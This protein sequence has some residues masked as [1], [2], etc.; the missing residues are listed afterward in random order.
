MATDIIYPPTTMSFNT[1]K[2]YSIDD[3]YFIKNQIRE[4]LGNINYFS[5]E[6]RELFEKMNQ[7]VPQG[8]RKKKFSPDEDWRKK[9][10]VQF[11]KKESQDQNEKIYHELKGYLNKISLNNYQ[12][13]LEEI[14]KLLAT[15]QDN[16]EY[17]LNILLNDILKKARAEPTYCVYYV[18]IILGLTDKVNV[19]KFINE[20]KGNYYQ[21]INKLRPVVE[22]SDD[23]DSDK[24]SENSDKEGDS[25]NDDNENNDEEVEQNQIKHQRTICK[26]SLICFSNET[27]KIQL[28]AGF[29]CLI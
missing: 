18:K 4:Q 17:Y 2:V 5:K 11:I 9:K 28:S 21:T 19:R 12:S 23:E 24:D 16:K 29:F 25:D 27:L 1:P 14:N 7:S 20:L 26:T 8:G 13:I 22:K 10:G 15:F 3:F 6:T